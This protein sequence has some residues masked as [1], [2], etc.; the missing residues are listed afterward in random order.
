MLKKFTNNK[1]NRRAFLG[2]AA[3]FCAAGAAA[4]FGW[5]ESEKK[6][7]L[8]MFQESGL[9]PEY[10]FKGSASTGTDFENPP[11]GIARLEPYGMIA[12]GISREYVPAGIV[13][14]INKKRLPTLDQAISLPRLGRTFESFSMVRLDHVT[15]I[16]L[17][18]TGEL[19]NA[20]SGVTSIVPI[21]GDEI[22]LR[23]SRVYLYT[24]NPS[25]RL[26]IKLMPLTHPPKNLIGGFCPLN[27]RITLDLSDLTIPITTPQNN[28]A[29]LLLTLAWHYKETRSPQDIELALEKEQFSTLSASE[30]FRFIAWLHYYSTIEGSRGERWNPNQ[31]TVNIATTGF[32]KPLVI[33]QASTKVQAAQAI[34]NW[35]KLNKEVLGFDDAAGEQLNVEETALKSSKTGHSQ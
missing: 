25:D 14:I 32:E 33:L 10:C 6:Q 11:D 5:P 16:S 7:V 17:D 21:C 2:G 13:Q 4:W 12:S 3:G 18:L 19:T 22:S 27:K 24:K 26:T 29:T 28:L 30:C 20:T 23:A 8:R 31:L 9:I 35:L 15:K 1:P 34:L